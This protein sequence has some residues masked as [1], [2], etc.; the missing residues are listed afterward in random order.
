MDGEKY[1]ERSWYFRPFSRHFLNLTKSKKPA[2]TIFTPSFELYNFGYEKILRS[3]T[4]F[5]E[6]RFLLENNKRNML[7]LIFAL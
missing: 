2:Q 1:V 6:I 4:S 7:S 5:P 3:F